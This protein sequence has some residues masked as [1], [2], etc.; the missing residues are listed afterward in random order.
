[1]P[2]HVLN[3]LDFIGPLDEINRLKETIGSD[4]DFN[5]LI[6]M[7]KSLNL[8]EGSVTRQAILAYI[9]DYGRKDLTPVESSTLRQLDIKDS[10]I[11]LP[12]PDETLDFSADGSGF[13]LTYAEAGKLYLENL[14]HYGVLSWYD[15]C[16][17]NWGT[18]WNAYEC[19]WDGNTLQFY[20]AWSAPEPVIAALSKQYPLL[21]INHRW[22]DEDIG[23]NCGQAAYLSG[24]Q[25]W[26]VEYTGEDAVQF[27]AEFW[28][29][30]LE[31]YL[32]EPVTLTAESQD[33]REASNS[34]GAQREDD[35]R[36]IPQEKET[37]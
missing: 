35:R 14:N 37:L 7:P 16:I 5:A 18:K 27:A 4:F 34:L 12:K 10:H 36:E 15:W 3:Q 21:G 32:E 20:T 24:E 22:A 17:K 19:F 31:E 28:G 9:T 2:N 6:P 13:H 26:S 30:P 1:M 25:Q 33:M 8:I 23:S 11:R 29:L